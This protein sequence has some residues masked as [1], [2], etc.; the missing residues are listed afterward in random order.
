MS[1]LACLSLILLLVVAPVILSYVVEYLRPNRTRPEK[2][3]WAED[4]AI[5]Y[6]DVG[7]IN[8]RYIKTGQGPNLVLLHTLRT[9]LDIF[10]K[11]I[12]QLS[13]SFTVHAF[14][15]PG[16]GW[17]DI[18]DADYSMEFFIDAVEKIFE[19]LDINDAIVAGVS[20]GGSIPLVMAG[21]NNPRIKGVVSIN[22]YDYAGK[23]PARG[24]LIARFFMSIIF[25]P[26][27]GATFM[28]FR[29]PLI[30]KLVFHGGVYDPAS[31]PASFLKECYQVG[32]RPGQLKGF[33]NL[34]RNSDSFMQAH[35][36]YNNISVPVLILYG[37]KD[38]AHADERQ[39]TSTAIPGA[40]TETIEGTGHFLSLEKP[41]L[42]VDRINRFSGSL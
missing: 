15:Y 13:R 23:G 30:E 8:I 4:I 39:K 1:I 3:V 40:T 11:M 36:F 24:N 12:P 26:V 17:S 28:R 32:E 29:I 7:D 34:I 5:E 9:Q 33:I 14:D 16:H 21:K 27:I 10:Q 22:P 41:E 38:W 19:R 2:L 20:I 35:R 25:V 37:E 42:L 6:V 18:P 31:L